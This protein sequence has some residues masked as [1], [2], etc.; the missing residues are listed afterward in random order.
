MELSEVR[1]LREARAGSGPALA[2]LWEQTLDVSWSIARALR[3]EAQATQAVALLR[4]MVAD[5]ARG[6]TTDRAWRDQVLELLWGILAE[7]VQPGDSDGIQASVDDVVA[8]AS[9]PRHDDAQRRM[10]AELDRA[11]HRDRMIYLFHLVGRCPAEAIARYSGVDEG[12]VRKVRTR[13]AFRLVM[14]SRA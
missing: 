10:R 8:A 3:D 1:L 9:Q 5:R 13:L 2:E 14:A 6:L 12:E 11:P 4:G 7:P